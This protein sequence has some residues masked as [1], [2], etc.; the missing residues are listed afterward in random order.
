MNTELEVL[1]ITEEEIDE[2]IEREL[3]LFNDEY[4]DMDY[5][6]SLL[7]RICELTLGEAER[8]M[9]EAHH[10]GKATVLTG[11]FNELKPY[12]EG[13]CKGGV[14]AEIC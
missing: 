3:V 5:V 8:I 1:E 2:T 11:T 12:R 6:T 10:R 14:W 4:N 7:M 9:L 13:I